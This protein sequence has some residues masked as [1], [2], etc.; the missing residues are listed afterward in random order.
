MPSLADQVRKAVAA[1]RAE[2]AA[3]TREL[4]RIDTTN[5]PGRN[6]RACAEL[7]ARRM[8]RLGFATSMTKI[9][10][11]KH[12]AASGRAREADA[13]PRYWVHASYGPGEP[14][15]YFHGHYDVVPASRPGQFQPRQRNGHIFGRGSADMKGGL[16]AMLFAARALKDLKLALRGRIEFVFVP[17]EET[18]GRRGTAA[19]FEHRLLRA[20]S[21][22]MI[23]AEPTSG[24]IWNANRGAISMRVTVK[25]KPAHVGLAFRGVNAFERMLAVARALEIEKRRIGRRATK[26]R[27]APP[28]ARRSILLIGGRSEGGSNFNVVPAEASFTIDRRINPEENLAREKKRLLEILDR[29]RRSG[30]EL[31]AEIF[32]EG[33]SASLAESHPLSRALGESVRAITGRAPAIEMCPG[34]LET[35]YYAARGIP[36]LAYGPGL[37]SV[38]HGPNEFVALREMEKCAAVYALTAV[39]LFGTASVEES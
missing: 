23:T 16:V 36:A 27:I 15:I 2:M 37:L 18:G 34:L 17:D 38:S 4:V 24:A 14:V 35:R 22:G 28:A 1:H 6:Y 20:N 3:L 30:I 33:A 21:A 31:E 19:L 32:Q 7:L 5:P 25:G 26:F 29:Q 11:P 8:R 9:P 10:A 12:A 13:G 39:R